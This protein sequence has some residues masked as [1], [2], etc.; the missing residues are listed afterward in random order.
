MR[1]ESTGGSVTIAGDGV[2]VIEADQSEGSITVK[3]GPGCSV[4]STWTQDHHT[5]V[6]YLNFFLIKV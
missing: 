1:A 5:D 3:D 4:A 2:T 6:S